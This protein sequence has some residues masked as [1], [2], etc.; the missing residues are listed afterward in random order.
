MRMMFLP[1]FLTAALTLSASAQTA[2]EETDPLFFTGETKAAA[3]AQLLRVPSSAPQIISPDGKTEYTAGKDFVWQ[4]GTRTV[5]LTADSRIPFKTT[6]ELHPPAK[7][8]NA[9]DGQRGTNQWM[10][11]GPHGLMH[12]LQCQAAYQSADEWK[13][14]FP[15]A[16]PDEQLGKLRAKI[17]AKEPVKFVMLGDSIS[18]EADASALAKAWPN[19]PG[20]PTLV[21]QALEARGAKVTLKNFSVGGMDSKW[22]TTK[23]AEVIAEKPDLLLV[24]FGMN[25]AS[26]RR[27]PDEFVSLTKKIYEPV[28]AALPDCTVILVSS[29]TANSEWKHSAPE[30][31]PQYAAALGKLTGPGIAFADVTAVWTAVEG[32]KKHMDLSGNGLNHPNDLGHRLYADTVLAVIGTTP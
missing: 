14:P 7:S 10:F 15:A 32:R 26:G 28:R 2:R 20:Y 9:Y 16:A 29:M 12:S 13:V 31:Y 22:G 11:F 25:D 1:F 4:Q 30:L 3:T 17:R 24:A 19:Q 6:A 21:A 5:T 23:L 8:P 18:T 27:K